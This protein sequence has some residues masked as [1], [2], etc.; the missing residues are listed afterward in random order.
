MS[1]AS[2]TINLLDLHFILSSGAHIDEMLHLRTD[3]V[4][5]I[6]KRVEMLNK[7]GR[8]RKLQVLHGEALCELDL[9]KQFV[10]LPAEQANA[11]ECLELNVRQSCDTLD[12]QRR[13]VHGFRA[14]TGCE[15]VNLKRALGYTEAEARRELAMCWATIRIAGK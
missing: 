14:T 10:Y 9:F 15:F 2:E 4:L 6:E 3:K 12:V 7:E 1:W 5:G 8:I 11:E 13:G